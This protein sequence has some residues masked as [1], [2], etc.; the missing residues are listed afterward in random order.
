[1]TT[2]AYDALPSSITVTNAGV[3]VSACDRIIPPGVTTIA[4]SLASPGFKSA[5]YQALTALEADGFISCSPTTATLSNPQPGA[6]EQEWFGG[7]EEP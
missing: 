2:I 3:P 7:Q 6:E 5:F 4:L 1:M